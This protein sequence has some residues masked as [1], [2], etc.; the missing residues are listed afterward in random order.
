[1]LGESKR[2][3]VKTKIIICVLHCVGIACVIALM[4]IPACLIAGEQYSLS[5]FWTEIV[6]VL[7]FSLL[8]MVILF[9]CPSHK[10]TIGFPAWSG[11]CGG[12]A[13]GILGDMQ[14][15]EDVKEVVNL[16]EGVAIFGGAAFFLAVLYRYIKTVRE[17]RRGLPKKPTAGEE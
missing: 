17:E 15:F 13:G 8:S 16:F 3:F 6:A 10:L 5:V 9:L 2:T 11:F 12:I 1:M 4:Q 14:D 7:G